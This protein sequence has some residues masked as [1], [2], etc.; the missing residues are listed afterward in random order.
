MN[1]PN[2][3]GAM[4]SDELLEERGLRDIRRGEFRSHLCV[5]CAMGLVIG[6]AFGVLSCWFG[7]P[8]AASRIRHLDA[9][10]DWVETLGPPVFALLFLPPPCC[11]ASLSLA[12]YISTRLAV[13]WSGARG[14]KPGI[15]GFAAGAFVFSIVVTPFLAQVLHYMSHP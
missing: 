8:Y 4:P 11:L 15:C 12:G 14:W 5:S 7:I 2:A 9:G 3:V 6:L 13:H 10:M 1:K